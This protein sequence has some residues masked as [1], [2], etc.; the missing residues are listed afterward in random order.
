MHAET[1]RRVPRSAEG[2]S[3]PGGGQDAGEVVGPMPPAADDSE[4]ALPMVGPI[5]AEAGDVGDDP[6]NLPI[7]HEVTLEGAPSFLKIL[8]PA[9]DSRGHR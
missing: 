4:E 5:A 9:I 6:Y 1:L 2:D 8:Q 7:T 3:P